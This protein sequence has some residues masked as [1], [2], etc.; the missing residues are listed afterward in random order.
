MNRSFQHDLMIAEV[1]DELPPYLSKKF[2][3]FLGL[4]E[5]DGSVVN[6]TLDFANSN[7]DLI[8]FYIK[9]F[10]NFFGKS[11]PLHFYLSL[12]EALKNDEKKIKETLEFWETKVE[13]SDIKY[14]FNKKG[15]LVLGNMKVVT[16]NKYITKILR[17]FL[18][19]E[20]LG[21]MINDKNFIRGYISGFFAAEGTVLPEKNNP[22]IPHSIQLPSTNKKILTVIE[23]Y[24]KK[25]DID[26]RIVAK[27]RSSNYFCVIITRY[28][29]FKKF[30]RFGLANLSKEKENKLK[31]GLNSYKMIPRNQ[32]KTSIKILKL[33]SQ[34]PLSRQELYVLTKRKEQQINSYLYSK[35]SHLL[36]K[37]F[38]KKNI[39]AGK[40]FWELTDEGKKFLISPT[41]RGMKI[42]LS[43]I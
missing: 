16:T 33:L 7:P 2:G 41:F 27:D 4:I 28:D 23:N 12:P 11:Y 10:N 9:C 35:S 25:F 15:R 19:T 14:H 6:R 5:G 43:E 18:S 31:L 30:H 39:L 20:F 38:I 3:A 1:A 21:R 37:G 42:D 36:K 22:K 24:I 8:T 26:C 29:N 40:I 13:T 32:Q 34:G 17:N